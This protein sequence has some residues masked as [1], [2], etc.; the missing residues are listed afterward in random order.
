MFLIVD[1]KL[2][3]HIHWIILLTHIITNEE[4]MVNCD[5]SKLRIR[6]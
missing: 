4:K 1:S 5:V 2:N 3:L 6:P